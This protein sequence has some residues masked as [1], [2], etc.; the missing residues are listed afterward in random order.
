MSFAVAKITRGRADEFGNF[1]GV[2]EFGTVDLDDH[3]RVAKKN[4]RGGFD[5]AGLARASGPEKKEIANRAA[6]GVQAGAEDLIEVNE[7]L[8]AFL[9]ADDTGAKRLVEIAGIVAADCGIQLLP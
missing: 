4:F 1:V 9:L 5:D 6:G 3:A 7:S 2:L 8:H